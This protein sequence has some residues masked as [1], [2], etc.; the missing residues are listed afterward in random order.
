MQHNKLNFVVSTV[1]IQVI[2]LHYVSPEVPCASPHA[3]C[4]AALCHHRPKP[5]VSD[6]LETGQ[7]ALKSVCTLTSNVYM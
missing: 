7:W 2:T 5:Q 6:V 4:A 3:A 1:L